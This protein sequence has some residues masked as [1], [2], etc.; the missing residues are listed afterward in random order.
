MAG[1]P[2]QHIPYKGNGPAFTD[3]VGGQ[4][5]LMFANKPGSLPFVQ[6]G[7]IKAIAI[8]SAK[9]DPQLPNIPSVAETVPGFEAS[10][11]WGVLGPAGLPPDVLDRLN[12]AIVKIMAIRDVRERMETLGADPATSTPKEYQ[13]L[14][15]K[16]LVQYGQIVKRSGMKLE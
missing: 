5:D 2:M 4:V 8:T 12:A 15:E 10:T 14:I 6:N 13:A 3:L 7:K 11:W 16:E 1:I 9:R